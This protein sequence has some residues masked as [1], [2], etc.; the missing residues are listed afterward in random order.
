M[1]EFLKV[2]VGAGFWIALV[3]AIWKVWSAQFGQMRKIAQ[4][5]LTLRE[6]LHKHPTARTS[7]G[8]RCIVCNSKSIKNWGLEGADDVRRIFIC[9]HCNTRLYRSEDW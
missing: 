9:N 5:T 6:Y 1:S 2:V 3:A 8:I 4:T 7:T